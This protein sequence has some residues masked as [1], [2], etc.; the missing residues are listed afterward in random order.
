MCFLTVSDDYGTSDVTVFSNIY[1]Q[2]QEQLK[3]NTIVLIN[4]TVEKYN[5]KIHLVLRT[6]KV[7][8]I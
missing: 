6:L 4:A 5:D 8:S 7:I 1:M 2:Y 3:E